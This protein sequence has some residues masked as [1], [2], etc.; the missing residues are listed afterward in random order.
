MNTVTETAAKATPL[1]ELDLYHLPWDSPEVAADP[2]RFFDEARKKHPWLAK[3]DAGYVVF[4]Y[5]AIRDL[6]ELDMQ[7][8]LRP[9]FDG[10]IEFLGAEGTP[11]GRFTSEQMLALSHDE[12]RVL[13]NTFAAR[14]TP[15]YANQIRPVMQENMA[16]L[17]EEWLPKGQFDFEEFSSYYPVSVM[18]R[19]I[20]APIEEIPGLR[21][22]LEALGLA[23]SLD[24]SRVPD[25]QKAI[26]HIDEFCQKLIDER[27]AN[28][29]TG[30]KDLLDI[31]IEASQ[32]GGISDRKLTDLLIFLFV[33]GYD[34]SKNVFTFMMRE[35]TRHPEIYQRCAEDLDYCRKCVE[36]FLRFFNPSHSFRFTDA[37]IEYDGVLFPKDTMLFFSLSMSGRDPTV[38]E[39]PEKFD[40]ERV[41][42][43]MHRQ[44]AFGLGKHMCLGQYIARAQLQE[45]LHMVAKHLR[46]PRVVGEVE[47]RPF[48]GIWGLKSLPIEFEA[49]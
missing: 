19:M 41:I 18:T 40:P 37:E 44:I 12:H 1:A 6:M 28:P 4:G 2:Y 35:M 17:L 8:K 5:Q 39:N 34:T 46:N 3:T 32:E 24:R 16:R 11:W 21:K 29:R 43:P 7:D 38:F 10:I 42:D 31:L 48:P 33:A 13:R 22:S 36:E 30:E 20:G 27:R 26:I 14:F 23:Y 45:G 25:L 49:A 47:Y 15:R 9:S